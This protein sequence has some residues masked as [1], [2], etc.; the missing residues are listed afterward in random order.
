MIGTAEGDVD[1]P[2]VWIV[3]ADHWTRACL[4]AELSE[5]GYDVVGFE[6]VREALATLS[7]PG[8]RR[9]Q[10]II[11]DLAGQ[12]LEG[13]RIEVLAR[14]GAPLIGIAGGVDVA[15]E[16]V[17][18]LPWAALLRRPLSLGAIADTVDRSRGGHAAPL[19]P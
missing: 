4:G 6:T 9:A 19:A 2:V 7:L 1:E 17:Q 15:Q 11:V 14:A 18:H 13:Q 3:D 10:V 12:R 16:L 8:S 5:R